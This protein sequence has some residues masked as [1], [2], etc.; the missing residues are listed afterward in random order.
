[1]PLHFFIGQ[2]NIKGKTGHRWLDPENAATGFVIYCRKCHYGLCD[3][4]EIGQ[5]AEYPSWHVVLVNPCPRCEKATL[6]GVE[7][8]VIPYPTKYLEATVDPRE[9]KGEASG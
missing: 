5:S 8:E 4:T 6:E 1:M 3:H 9:D 7:A 2:K